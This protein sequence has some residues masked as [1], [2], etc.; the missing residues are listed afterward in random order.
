VFFVTEN[1]IYLF[2]WIGLNVDMEWVQN[3]FGVHSAAQ[4]D[5]DRT[6]LPELDNTLSVRIRSVIDSVR[7]QRHR[8]MRVSVQHVSII[9]LRLL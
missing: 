9:V 8:S 4:I 7:Q 1:G 2:L 6:S 3:V 5:I